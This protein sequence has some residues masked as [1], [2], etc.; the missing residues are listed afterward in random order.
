MQELR[1]F[2]LLNTR[3]V[4]ITEMFCFYKI[5]MYITL[6]FIIIDFCSTKPV[7]ILLITVYASSLTSEKAM[8]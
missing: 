5:Q 6:K 8:P 1:M 4:F 3:T 2:A 7:D